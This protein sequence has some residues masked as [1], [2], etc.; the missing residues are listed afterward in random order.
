MNARVRRAEN[1]TLVICTVIVVAAL[2]I[3]LLMN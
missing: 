2:L 1:I 3:G